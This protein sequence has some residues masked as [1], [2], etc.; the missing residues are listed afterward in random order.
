MQFFGQQEGALENRL[1]YDIRAPPKISWSSPGLVDIP[2]C[3]SQAGEQG[4]N[5]FGTAVCR[6]HCN[7][8]VSH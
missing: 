6:G 4:K 8:P 1:V 7:V 2:V 3:L 5:A